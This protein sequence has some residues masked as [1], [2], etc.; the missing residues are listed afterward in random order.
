M[1]A[2]YEPVSDAK[3]VPPWSI[4]TLSERDLALRVP[5]NYVTVPGVS[6]RQACF[7]HNVFETE[8]AIT[9]FSNLLAA[10]YRRYEWDLFWDPSR[11]VWSFCPIQ[12][13]QVDEDGA[14]STTQMLFN[15]STVTVSDAVITGRAITQ[16]LLTDKNEQ[17]LSSQTLVRRQDPGS[18]VTSDDDDSQTATSLN[19]TL[20]GSPTAP[21]TSAQ[22]SSSTSSPDDLIRLGQY[23]C[24]ESI[25]LPI[26]AAVLDRYFESTSNTLEAFLVY[27]RL[28]LHAAA[29]SVSSPAGSLNGSALPASGE[30][31]SAFL[32]ANLTSFLYTPAALAEERANVNDT[33]FRTS[34]DALPL[35][36]YINLTNQGG[37]SSSDNGWP[38]EIYLEFDQQRRLLA[39]FGTIDGDMAS[40]NTSEDADV[41]F[42]QGYMRT[43]PANVE[44]SNDGAIESGCLYNPDSLTVAGNN[45]SWAT[46]GFDE[47]PVE[48]GFDFN[49]TAI[50]Q[51]ANLTTCGISSFLNTTIFNQTADQDITLYDDFLRSATW[52]WQYGE[53]RNVSEDEENSSRIRCAAMDSTLNGRWRVVDCTDRHYSACRANDDPFSWHISFSKA[54]YTASNDI[55]DDDQAFG[56][57]LTAIENQHLFRQM[58]AELEDDNL[59]W[60]NFNS[61]DVASCWVVGVNNTC[62]Y[63]QREIDDDSRKIIVPT[64]AAVIVFIVTAL[65]LFVKCAANRQT[66]KRR[67]RRKGETD[68]PYEGIPQ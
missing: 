12:I 49:T 22:E 67:R 26:L 40:Y 56:V 15:S 61:L 14:T 18:A 8:T 52:S 32:S 9:C 51:V 20:G 23:S 63:R 46:Y 42:P 45:N 37:H 5:I 41:I 36:G 64:I 24:S 21:T 58:R 27:L 38:N 4:A 13:P 10:G 29:A 1:S 6:L 11:R 25:D 53:P 59:I 57:P 48:R 68:F 39:E 16:E 17:H 55:C 34:P 2:S 31:L 60:V 33:W 50:P 35:P 7:G 66:N 54:T 62:P 47:F 3:P 44:L 19:P 30:V 65:T 28:N 43:E